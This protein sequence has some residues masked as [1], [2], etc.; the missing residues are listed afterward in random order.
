MPRNTPPNSLLTEEDFVLRCH[1][2]T[3]AITLHLNDDSSFNLGSYWSRTEQRVRPV[4]AKNLL[5]ETQVV[6]GAEVYLSRALGRNDQLAQ[7]ACTTAFNWGMALIDVQLQ[8]VAPIDPTT[9]EHRE[10]LLVKKQQAEA[11]KAAG[12]Q[13]SEHIEIVERNIDRTD[14][15]LRKRSIP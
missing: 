10:G 9:H 5:T 15:K 13:E 6:E 11:E 3:R 12:M 1:P 8:H 14:V 7:Q 2:L 4:T